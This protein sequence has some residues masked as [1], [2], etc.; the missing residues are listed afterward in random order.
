MIE[1]EQNNWH[2]VTAR[3]PSQDGS[4]VYAVKTTGIY[5]RPSCASRTPKRENVT[6]FKLP[7]L[8]ERAGYRACKRCRPADE[9][10]DPQLETVRALCRYIETNKERS[11]TLAELG[12]QVGLSASHVQRTFKKTVGVTPQAYLEACRLNA[13]KTALQQGDDISGATFGAGYG[14]SSGLYGRADA[15]LGMTPKTYQRKG[16]R[17]AI[18][19]AVADCSLGKLLVAAT[20]KGI[21]AVRLGDDAAGLEQELLEEFSKADVRRDAEWLEGRLTVVVQYLNGA[22]PHLDLPLDVRATAFQ[23]R[24]WQALQKIPHGE[25]RS[26]GQVAEAIGQ[27]SAV[28]A[29]ARACAA[30]PVALVVPCHRVVRSNGSLSGYRWGVERKRHL[31]RQES[32]QQE[33]L[34]RDLQQ[35]LQRESADE[36]A[37]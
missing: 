10:T 28:R 18:H 27:P 17:A 9:M 29:V 37:G 36:A 21:C 31:L 15:A 13:V 35:D 32:L 12:E 5:C 16:E 7:E 19:Y 23:Q 26:Y 3:D 25:T 8:A 1:T 20:E 14:S 30:N 22:M 33:N 11:L 24:V 2:A 34:Q 6:F 4:F